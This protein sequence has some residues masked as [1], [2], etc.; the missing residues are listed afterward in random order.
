MLPRSFEI[1]RPAPK[2]LK[3]FSIITSTLF[4][5]FFKETEYCAAA[6][7]FKCTELADEGSFGTTIVTFLLLSPIRA[8][9]FETSCMFELK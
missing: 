7:T 9:N 6:R 1:S 2:G 4:P 8:F 3:Q 5:L